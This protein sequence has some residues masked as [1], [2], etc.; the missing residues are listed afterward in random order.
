VQVFIDT[1]AMLAIL[2]ASQPDHAAAERSL[3][4]LADENDELITHSYVV[5]EVNALVQ[6][7]L[8]MDALRDLHHAVLGAIPVTIVDRALHD[9]AVVA[10]LAADRR[11]VSL[12]DWVSFAFM[13]REQIEH[14]FAYDEHFV[15]QGFQLVTP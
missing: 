11:Q 12:V 7:R 13:R 8:G 15:E 2:D 10:Q 14:A 5:V 9:A 3:R 1:S 6:R 4:R